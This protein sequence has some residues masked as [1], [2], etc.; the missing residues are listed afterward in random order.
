VWGPELDPDPN[1][2]RVH[3]GHIRRKLEPNSAMPTYFITDAGV[4]YRFQP[5]D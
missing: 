1:L 4:G 3:M 5:G 2:L